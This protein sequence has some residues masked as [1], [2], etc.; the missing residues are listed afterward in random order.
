MTETDKRV[1]QQVTMQLSTTFQQNFNMTMQYGDFI[2][3]YIL[4]FYA[5]E[6]TTEEKLILALGLGSRGQDINPTVCKRRRS[7][8]LTI[9]LKPQDPVLC[10]R[11]RSI[12]L[13]EE[14]SVLSYIWMHIVH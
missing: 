8:N 10:R 5:G 6:P 14:T 1:F 11:K 3:T 2:Y 4:I 12:Y 7:L 13:Q 9:D